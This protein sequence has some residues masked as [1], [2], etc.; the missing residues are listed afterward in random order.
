MNELDLVIFHNAYNPITT[1]EL[2]KKIKKQANFSIAKKTLYTSI[3]RLEKQGFIIKKQQGKHI[4]IQQSSQ[5]VSTY[6]HN[7]IENQPHLIK[8]HIF[9]TTTFSILLAVLHK[10]LPITWIAE[11]TAL[12]QRHTRRYLIKL[13]QAA[14]ITKHPPKNR[15]RASTWTINKMS[16]EL[17]QFLEA[18]EEFKALT[19]IDSIDTNASLLWVQG[20]EF[21]IK[22]PQ[23]TDHPDFQET[24]AAALEQYGMKLLPAENIYFYTK[25]TLNLWDHAF[26]TVL[27]RKHDPTQLRYLAYLYKKHQPD[28]EEFTQKGSYYDPQT[29]QLI[30][31]FFIHHKETP[32]LKMQDIKELEKLYGS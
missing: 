23:T 1:T 9:T 19:I 16:S 30:L 2:H 4:F 28:P 27:S 22:T 18:Y 17:I 21:L 26:L 10:K 6:L 11:I 14:V 15:S 24:G 32:Y 3:Y 31:D 20:I 5:P 12:S 8:K 7:L 25:R 13:H 29:M